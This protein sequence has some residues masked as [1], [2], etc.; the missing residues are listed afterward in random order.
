MTVLNTAPFL[1]LTD[2]AAKRIRAI[3][4]ENGTTQMLRI[5]V[6]GGGC[7]GFQYTFLMDDQMLLDDKTF[8]R[9]GAVIVID[10]TSLELLNGAAIDF[11][12]DLTASMFVIKNPNATSGC[13]CGNS[14]S[15]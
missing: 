1:T 4:E 10:E 7:S 14:F 2:A 8:S 3:H 11:Q 6:Q 13:G 12:D 9:D 5:A 15:I